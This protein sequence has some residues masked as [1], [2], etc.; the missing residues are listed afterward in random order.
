MEYVLVSRSIAI[1]SLMVVILFTVLSYSSNVPFEH[2]V[3]LTGSIVLECPCDVGLQSK[4]KFNG[5]L[6]FAARIATSLRFKDYITLFRNY[7]LSISIISFDQ[8]GTYECLCN[9]S[10]ETKHILKIEGK[11]SICTVTL[12][13]LYIK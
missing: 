7:S 13:R 12:F 8:E 11:L 5:D 4:W 6:I 1:I 10:T 2:T 3:R 9:I